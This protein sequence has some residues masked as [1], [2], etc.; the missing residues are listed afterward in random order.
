MFSN[1]QNNA[2]Y[3]VQTTTVDMPKVNKGDKGVFD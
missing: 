1:T 2:A 3:L